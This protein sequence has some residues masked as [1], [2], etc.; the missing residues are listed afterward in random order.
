MLI[1][2]ICECVVRP[3]KSR[4]SAVSNDLMRLFKIQIGPKSKFLLSKKSVVSM[5]L[6]AQD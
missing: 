4:L 6:V 1:F 5:N 2:D 3:F